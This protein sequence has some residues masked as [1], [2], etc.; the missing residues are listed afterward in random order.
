MEDD[1]LMRQV[2]ER[3]P[4]KVRLGLVWLICESNTR[5]ACGKHAVDSA[6]ALSSVG[7]SR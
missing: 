4:G 3:E 1:S 6:L 5:A 2:F 7:F